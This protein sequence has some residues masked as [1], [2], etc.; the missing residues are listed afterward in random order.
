[1]KAQQNKPSD[2]ETLK[3][4]QAILEYD[5]KAELGEGAFWNHKTSELYWIDILQNQLHIYNPKT[6]VNRSFKTPSSI[7]TVVPTTKKDVALVALQD[8]VYTLNTGN[9]QTALFSDVERDIPSNRLNDG[10]CDPSGRL[11]VGSMAF[12][13]AQNAAKLYMV[14]EKGKASLKKDSVT[15]SNGIVWTKDK[16]TMYYIDTPT[17]EIKAYDYD[18][19][20]GE[21]SNERVA[22]KVDP[23]LGGPDGMAIDENDNLWVGMWNGNAVIQ[24]DSKTGKVLSRVDVPAHNITSCA[25]GGED[26][27]IL[28]I[29]S[30][31]IDM[32]D[33]EKAQFPKAGSVFKVKTDVKGVKSPFFR[34]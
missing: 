27:D 3:T 2:L 9:S 30:V 7:G 1:M 19:R 8:G 4:Y 12:N 5:T 18:D 17:S 6:K 26:L 28:Y 10:K 33:E 21:I 31:T 29:T 32:T 20:T 15:I 23:N 34:L 13:Q 24:F 16:K 25:F 11:W 22:V 14:D